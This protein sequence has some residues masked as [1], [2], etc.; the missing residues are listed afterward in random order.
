[1]IS[2]SSVKRIKHHTKNVKIVI[3]IPVVISASSISMIDE[4]TTELKTMGQ[5]YSIDDGQ[6][7][8]GY[9]KIETAKITRSKIRVKWLEEMNKV[10][11][12]D[13]RAKIRVTK[14]PSKDKPHERR[15]I[16]HND[17]DLGLISDSILGRHTVNK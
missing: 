7:D 12:S 1:M 2:K 16:E 10:R 8:S 5:K 13:Y 3:N 9:V 4:L 6:K 15:K 14:T 11:L 17:S